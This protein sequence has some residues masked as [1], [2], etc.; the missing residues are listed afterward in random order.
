VCLVT[1]CGQATPGSGSGQ[2]SE[3]SPEAAEAALIEAMV[4]REAIV[5]RAS[6]LTFTELFPQVG[7]SKALADAFRAD[8]LAVDAGRAFGG[9]LDDD[10]LGELPFDDPQADWRSFHVRV[11]VVEVFSGDVTVGQE[12]TVGLAFG[13]ALEMEVV[14]AGLMSMRDIVVFTR[15]GDF[16]VPYDPS[17][18]P[19][20][21]DGAFLSP[22]E[23]DRV[24]FP[25]VSDGGGAAPALSRFD[26]LPELRTV[27]S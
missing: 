4:N 21:W 2:A 1:A 27:A 16:V 19:G 26:T 11:E 5:A 13:S 3:L 23:G 8:V 9:S 15:P 6:G 10:P 14:S 17:I 24:P 25:A 7:E 18:T 22:V 20:V 12:L